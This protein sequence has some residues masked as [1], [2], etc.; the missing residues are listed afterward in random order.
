MRTKEKRQRRSPIPVEAD[1][2]RVHEGNHGENGNGKVP[3]AEEEDVEKVEPVPIA[4]RPEEKKACEVASRNRGIGF[5][6]IR[7]ILIAFINLVT[8]I[9]FAI[10]SKGFKE[11]IYEDERLHITT[12]KSLITQSGGLHVYGIAASIIALLRSVS[13]IT[14]VP[15]ALRP[16]VDPV[17]AAVANIGPGSSV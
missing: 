15:V 11:E 5:V 17:A 9:T 12:A 10:V 2:T 13:A 4:I 16:C 8:A 14:T 7:P 6:A 3:K 1:Y